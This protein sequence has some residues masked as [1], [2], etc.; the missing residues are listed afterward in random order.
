MKIKKFDEFVFETTRR[1]KAEKMLGG[2][3]GNSKIKTICIITPENPMAVTYDN[4][5]N[6]NIYNYFD[7]YLRKEQY[8]FYRV[9]GRYDNDEHSFFIYN[10]SIDDCK[11]I[12]LRWNQQSFIF[13]KNNNKTIFELW[14]INGDKKD[15]SLV[16]T[17]DY[18]I[19][20]NEKFFTI[21][22]KNLKFNIPFEYFDE[23]VES[24]NN[25][26]E[27]RFNKCENYKKYYDNYVNECIAEGRFYKNR[28]INRATLYGVYAFEHYWMKQ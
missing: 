20:D 26:V 7:W 25:Y 3:V 5:D 14:M 19:D 15:Y 22:S 18:I 28:R 1:R 13:I 16:E 12:G 11:Q 24:Y 8:H 23:V 27:D 4:V 9:T 6:K 21:V 10:L 17:K 2:L